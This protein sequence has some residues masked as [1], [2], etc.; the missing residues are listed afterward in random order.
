MPD[1]AKPARR[2]R[3]GGRSGN[4]RGS[5]PA[6][7]QMPWRLIENTDRPT[8]PLT[9][10]GVAAIHDGAMRILEEIGIEFL[11][12]EGRA[13]LGRAGC[14]I[15]GANVRMGRDFVMEMVGRCPSE[16]TLT[17]RNQARALKIGG[18]TLTFGNVSSPPNYWD[19]ETGKT[20]GT[21]AQCQNL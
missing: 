6:I 21:R 10:D 19:L 16:F 18:R 13:I 2:R 1:D 12:D 4:T 15:E 20:P 11:N 5:G 14:T 7:H 3:S 17:P 9:E 8:E